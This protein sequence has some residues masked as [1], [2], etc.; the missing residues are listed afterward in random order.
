MRVTC[1]LSIS[2]DG[3]IAGPNQSR[4]NPLGE[5]AMRLH[6]WHFEPHPDDQAVLDEWQNSPGAYVMGR[7]MFGPIRDEW[8]LDWK[9]WWGEEPP[10]HAPVFVLT[11][12]PR[13]PLPMAGGTTF[14]FV[15][16][17]LGTALEQAEA[18][19]GD[20]PVEIAGGATTVNAYLQAGAVDELH[21][22]ISP[23]LLGAGER[24]FDGVSSSLEL[25]PVH[26]QG[27]PAV[28]HV[29]YRVG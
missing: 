29:K 12:Y 24:L 10:Y 2:A 7:N 3:F 27:S 4:D 6:E 28:T 18:A 13:E 25:E 8:D 23:V 15:T 17:G 1:N 14:H 26:V 21:L 20:K 11:H 22:H 5:G 19:A 16:D 9:G